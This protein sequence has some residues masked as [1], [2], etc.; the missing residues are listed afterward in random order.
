MTANRSS[1]TARVSRKVRSAEGRCVEIT[2]STARAK[3][4]S[5]AVGIAQPR[6]A[7]PPPEALT[8]R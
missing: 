5:V 7:V 8:A 1:T 4:M 6:I 3:A 2:A